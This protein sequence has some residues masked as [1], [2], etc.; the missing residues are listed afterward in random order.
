VAT[1]ISGSG[2]GVEGSGIVLVAATDGPSCS[3][4]SLVAIFDGGMLQS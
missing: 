3:A 1:P 4:A 2:G